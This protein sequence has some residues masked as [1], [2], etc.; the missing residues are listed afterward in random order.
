[1][2]DAPLLNRA[3]ITVPDAAERTSY[4]TAVLYRAFRRGEIEGER[5]GRTVRL[6]VDSVEAWLQRN[7]S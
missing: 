4:S 7:K 1:M 2:I 3:R 5:A 6:Y